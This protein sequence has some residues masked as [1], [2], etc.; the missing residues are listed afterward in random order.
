M[1]ENRHSNVKIRLYVDK[2][3]FFQHVVLFGALL[4]CDKGRGNMIYKNK[5]TPSIE[6]L[7]VETH[8]YD[9]VTMLYFSRLDL[10][11]SMTAM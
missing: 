7:V 2:F 11:G 9:H 4:S 1:T 10:F 3:M 6:L 8:V 5:A